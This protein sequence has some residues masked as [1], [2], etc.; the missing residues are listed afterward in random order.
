MIVDFREPRSVA[1]FV[2]VLD[3]ETGEPIPHVYYADDREWVY[4]V[5][6]H[7]NDHLYFW[8][9]ETNER[10]RRDEFG[11]YWL[12]DGRIGREED[13]TIEMAWE[14]R[15]GPIRFIPNIGE[16]DQVQAI[17]RSRIADGGEWASHVPC[18]RLVYR[19][20]RGLR[21]F[22]KRYRYEW[23]ASWDDDPSGSEW[24]PTMEAA[25]FDLVYFGSRGRHVVHVLA[26]ESIRTIWPRF[27]AR[28][29]YEAPWKTSLP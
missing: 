1:R 16:P 8:D 4:R 7:E 2:T 21:R 23:Q 15:R 6:L 24:H 12:A 14:E 25:M 13:G 29:S 10:V 20:A 9:T 27:R 11:F 26:H 5:Y 18:I 22:W 28:R 3:G 19:N 17:I